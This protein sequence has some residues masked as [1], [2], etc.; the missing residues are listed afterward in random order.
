MINCTRLLCDKK[1]FYDEI[2]YEKGK[3]ADTNRPIVV[4]NTT[5]S[6]NL[7]CVHCYI[8]AKA[9]KDKNELTT[10]QA[11]LM[12]DDLAAFKAPVLLFSGG[13]PFMRPDMFELGLY[14]VSRGLRTVISTNGTL[15]TK[16]A[17]Q[18]VKEAGFSY[19]G[20]SLDGLEATNDTFR[21]EKGAFQKTLQG[22]RN[23]HAYGVRAGL[24][25]TINKHNFRDIAGIF[26]LIEEEGINRACFY[27]LVY[28]GR[29]SEMIKDDLT[30]EQARDVM[31]L[32]FER[33][34]RL[35]RKNGNAEIL[36]VDNHADGVYLYL[37][38]K[39]E[40]EKKAQEVLELLKIN[41]GNK[42]GI[43]I[44]DVDNL[45]FVHFDQFWRHYSLGNVKSRKFSEIWLDE[46]DALL[47]NLRNRRALL[48]GKCGRCRFQ[49]IC[50]GNFRVRAEAFYGDVW[51]ED[52]ACYLTEEEIVGPGPRTGR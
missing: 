42:S 25:F 15:I 52:P 35:S 3:P 12:I 8:D 44:A 18:K 26:D 11:R 30:K 17:A 33:T 5:K 21:K 22:I 38:L 45:G 7:K 34:I 40:N 51:Q 48:K 10:E 24:R 31:D 6:C 49:D 36:T 13:E 29:G 50:A 1:G 28:A 9:K 27:H 4:W 39:K 41:G 14:A 46:S 47:K 16:D 32:I 2:R 19:V 23:C 43:G 20:I 37:R